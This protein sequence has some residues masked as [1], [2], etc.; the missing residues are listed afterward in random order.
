MPD[1]PSKLMHASA[2]SLWPSLHPLRPQDFTTCIELPTCG[3]NARYKSLMGRAAVKQR[4][5]ARG[6]P[7]GA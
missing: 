7:L 5:G 4:M 6:L 3:P 2:T 1:A